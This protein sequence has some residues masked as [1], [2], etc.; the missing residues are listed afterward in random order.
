MAHIINEACVSCGACEAECPVQAISQG[1]ERYQID[2]KKC[3]DCAACVEV[4]PVEAITK[5]EG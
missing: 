2:P 4:C 3:T 1:E 5:A